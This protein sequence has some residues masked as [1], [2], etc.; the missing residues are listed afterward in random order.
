MSL[1]ID[2]RRQ[3]RDIDRETNPPSEVK[4]Y[5]LSAKELA[6]YNS[7]KTPTNSRGK[8]LRRSIAYYKGGYRG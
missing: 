3:R 7:I 8:S 5:T 1:S 6:K 2:N 4:E